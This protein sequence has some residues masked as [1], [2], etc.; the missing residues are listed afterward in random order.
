[1]YG[2]ET[3][4]NMS[5]PLDRCPEGMAWEKQKNK[6][7]WKWRT[8]TKSTPISAGAHSARV[9]SSLKQTLKS[10]SPLSATQEN[11]T[12]KITAEHMQEW[13]SGPRTAQSR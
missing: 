2:F 8:K 5:S 1:M 4:L 10:T 9:A 3:F 13:N 11:C 6:K 7:T 12:L